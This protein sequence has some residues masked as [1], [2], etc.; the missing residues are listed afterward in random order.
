M[1]LA[2]S[3]NARNGLRVAV[4]NSS[5]SE[6]GDSASVWVIS[7]VCSVDN[8]PF[9]QASSVRAQLDALLAVSIALRAWWLLVPAASASQSA[10]FV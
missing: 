9:R 6:P 1:C 10:A 7:A 8:S 4:S 2:F 3:F 5:S